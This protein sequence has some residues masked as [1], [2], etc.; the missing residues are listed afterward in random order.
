MRPDRCGLRPGRSLTSC[1]CGRVAR[2]SVRLLRNS[3]FC[4]RCSRSY[5]SRVRIVDTGPRNSIGR[6]SM[7]LP[8]A[9]ALL[10][11]AAAVLPWTCGCSSGSA[12]TK[13]AAK[14][15]PNSTTP[16]NTFGI[17]HTAGVTVRVIHHGRVESTAGSTIKG[18]S[19]Q[20]YES[21]KEALGRHRVDWNL[22][23]DWS[24]DGIRLSVNGRPYG[25]LKKGDKID[26]DYGMVFVNGTKREPLPATG[27]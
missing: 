1:K 4:H 10:C 6:A 15:T 9:H 5:D 2:R 27:R 8:R 21:W 3:P 25:E 7:Q 12:A 26:I 18:D 20:Y 13:T 22:D 23:G 24:K 17:W 19:R 16:A 14:A 11:L